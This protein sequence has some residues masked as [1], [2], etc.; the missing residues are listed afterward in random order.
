LR[1][2]ISQTQEKI[3]E[4]KNKIQSLPA[5]TQTLAEITNKRQKLRDQMAQQSELI[6]QLKLLIDETMEF[7][8]L[9]SEYDSATPKL[10]EDIELHSAY[11]TL[12]GAKGLQTQ[13][14][15]RNINS[16]IA[17]INAVLTTITTFRV[18]IEVSD[19]KINLFISDSIA[20]DLTKDIP[21][22]LAS[23]FQKFVI[24]LI[25]R[26][27]L[28]HS[29]FT[30]SKFVICDESFS[31]FDQTNLSHVPE[32]LNAVKS[33]Y[34]FVFIIS[35]IEL[36]QQCIEAPIYIN[37][38]ER[39]EAVASTPRKETR[40]RRAKEE[41]IKDKTYSALSIITS[42]I[43][44]PEGCNPR[45]YANIINAESK[46]VE[47]ANLTEKIK[48]VCGAEIQRKSVDKH[49]ESA[50]HVK[51]LEKTGKRE[52]IETALRAGV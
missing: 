29:L 35:H 10:R 7:I 34:D 41:N 32:L 26:L 37:V 14:I 44:A 4:Y 15:K 25:F 13:V 27:S 30:A 19:T 49:A 42:Y 39:I 16:V 21:I 17:K 51:F 12:L 52:K 3:T 48:C 18:A 40:G 20:G 31:T 11:V 23:G 43:R 2:S 33:Y 36:L 1:A 5:L 28:T 47:K 9:K 8:D 22:E 24:S 6:G 38:E 46:E 45:P 50:R